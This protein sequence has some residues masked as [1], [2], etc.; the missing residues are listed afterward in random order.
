METWI[1]AAK[2]TPR[3]LLSAYVNEQNE[4]QR[5]IKDLGGRLWRRKFFYPCLEKL[6]PHVNFQNERMLGHL[7]CRTRFL[8]FQL[9]QTHIGSLSILLQNGKKFCQGVEHLRCS[10]TYFSSPTDDESK[11]FDSINSTGDLIWYRRC[12]MRHTPQTKHPPLY[13][14][15]FG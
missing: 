4:W 8:I 5:I 9:H 3:Q 11:Q 14:S 7:C 2:P 15:G 10:W 1:G 13:Q 6:C 12:M